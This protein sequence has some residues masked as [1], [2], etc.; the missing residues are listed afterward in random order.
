MNFYSLKAFLSQAQRRKCHA[1]TRLLEKSRLPLPLAL[2]ETLSKA[3]FISKTKPFFI[4]TIQCSVVF[5]AMSMYIVGTWTEVRTSIFWRPEIQNIW[6][7]VRGI[8]TLY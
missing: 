3:P 2:K 1:F 8:D 4:F 7:P 5:I 6:L